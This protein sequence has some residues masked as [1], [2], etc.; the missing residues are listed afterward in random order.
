M[1]ILKLVPIG[2]ILWAYYG[3][4]DYN[5]EFLKEP[6]RRVRLTFDKVLT[7]IENLDI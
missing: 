5:P 4:D 1:K 6:F 3:S 7:K 2:I